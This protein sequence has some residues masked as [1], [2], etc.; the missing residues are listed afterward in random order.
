MIIWAMFFC[1]KHVR[2]EPLLIVRMKIQIKLTG[3]DISVGRAGYPLVSC[4]IRLLN[5]DEGQYRNTDQPN[6]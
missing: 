2:L 4:E 3:D 1:L 6:P 5:W